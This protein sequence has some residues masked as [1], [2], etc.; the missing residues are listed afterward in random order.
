MTHGD[1]NI[2]EEVMIEILSKKKA[3]ECM[4]IKFPSWDIILRNEL[5][6]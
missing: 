3:Y 4:F 5:D 2:Y 1:Y 6:I